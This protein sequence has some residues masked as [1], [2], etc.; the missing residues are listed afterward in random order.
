M[1]SVKQK[2]SSGNKSNQK[3]NA[4]CKGAAATQLLPNKATAERGSSVAKSKLEISI[5]M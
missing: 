1:G 4:L 3:V 5:F 2:Q